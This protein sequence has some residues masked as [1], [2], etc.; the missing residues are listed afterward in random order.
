MSRFGLVGTVRQILSFQ[1]NYFGSMSIFLGLSL[2]WT[3]LSLMHAMLFGKRIN[4]KYGLVDGLH[5]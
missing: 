2:V 4:H 1:V 3:L 5:L